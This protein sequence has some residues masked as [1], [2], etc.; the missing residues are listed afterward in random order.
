MKSGGQ[1]L[2]QM[3]KKVAFDDP[4]GHCR[5]SHPNMF[6]HFSFS[7]EAR[8]FNLGV[9]HTIIVWTHDPIAIGVYLC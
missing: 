7:V 8:E 1:G 9:S 2:D 6:K 5:R 3:S 4:G